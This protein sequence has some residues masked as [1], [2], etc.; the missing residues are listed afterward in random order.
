MGAVSSATRKKGES[1]VAGFPFLW[2]L[3]PAVNNAQRRLGGQ[4]SAICR[5]SLLAYRFGYAA[6]LL[7]KMAKN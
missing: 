7:P 5:Q 1:A 6:S 4:F 3:E 2:V